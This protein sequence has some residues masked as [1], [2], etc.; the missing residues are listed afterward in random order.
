ML[1][2][3]T[4]RN[5]P[6]D[7]VYDSRW[8][9]LNISM[10]YFYRSHNGPGVDSAANGNEYREKFMRVKVPMRNDDTLPSSCVDGLEV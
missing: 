10:I 4:L 9:H 6:E 7:R 5:K 1:M 2:V 3:E 8:C